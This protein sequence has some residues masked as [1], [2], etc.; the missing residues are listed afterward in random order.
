MI[1]TIKN[2]NIAVKFLMS[3]LFLIVVLGIGVLGFAKQ[4]S[5]QGIG[6][7]WTDS[8]CINGYYC[9]GSD[10]GANMGSCQVGSGGSGCTEYSCPFGIPVPLLQAIA[11]PT[12]PYNVRWVIMD[13]HA[14]VPVTVAEII[15]IFLTNT[16]RFVRQAG[17]MAAET[18][19]AAEVVIVATA[20]AMRD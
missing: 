16:I 10:G 4:G 1:S 20:T 6:S 14:V 12:R 13:L 17:V 5:A 15:V 19:E 8:D 11:L 3:S 9:Y 7:C 18:V 2:R